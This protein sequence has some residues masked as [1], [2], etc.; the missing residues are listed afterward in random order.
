MYLFLGRVAPPLQQ[1]L[2]A[3]QE[4]RTCSES[5]SRAAT[6][7]SLVAKHARATLHYLLAYT[8]SKDKAH[9]YATTH[10]RARL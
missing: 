7:V 4:V 6:A 8:K 5:H 10:G 1:L 3:V 2:L 9:V